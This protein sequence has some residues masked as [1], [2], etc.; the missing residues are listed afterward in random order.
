MTSNIND[1]FSEDSLLMTRYN[2]TDELVH[3]I[4]FFYECFRDNK[5]VGE[6][7]EVIIPC[8][9]LVLNVNNC[10]INVIDEVRYLA[11]V[12]FSESEMNRR[13]MNIYDNF[14]TL[15]DNYME[16]DWY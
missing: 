13:L 8:V 2:L 16:C 10:E 3:K 12:L 9:L 14:N 6:D 11:S 7:I 1:F 4:K 15:A 5:I